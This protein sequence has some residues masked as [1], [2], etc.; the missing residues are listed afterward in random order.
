MVHTPS[1]KA[2][3]MNPRQDQSQGK[4]FV[5]IHIGGFLFTHRH[6]LS[7]FKISFY[8]GTKMEKMD[9]SEGRLVICG[10]A[11]VLDSSGIT[12]DTQKLKLPFWV[13]W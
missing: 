7:W 2:T 6:F 11:Y 3:N 10:W 9:S 8:Y 12:W 5:P 13:V 1:G 4:E